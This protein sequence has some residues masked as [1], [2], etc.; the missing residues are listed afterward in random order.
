M[1][2]K[3][4]LI[5]A[6]VVFVLL[7]LAAVAAIWAVDAAVN[8]TLREMAASSPAAESTAG[9][10]AAET[11]AG[12]PAADPGAGKPSAQ[13]GAGTGSSGG[14]G[15]PVQGGGAGTSG[16]NGSGGGDASGGNPSSGGTGQAAG[17]Q[18]ANSSEDS[19]LQYEA[20]ITAERAALVQEN[21]TLAEKA[22]VASTLMKKFSMAELRQFTDIARD[23]IT[24][25]EKRALRD[26][27]VERLSEEEYNE[28]IAIAAK[29]GLSQGKTYDKVAAK[30]KKG[31]T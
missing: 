28:L 21:I 19:A 29:Y 27:F 23:G 5:V 18:G 30:E 1:R 24:V 12:S 13:P 31:G 15:S 14:G 22:L 8:W 16:G 3:T 6:S 10:S 2:K 9:K 11:G 4:W 26:I 25:E 7:I 20:D 17:E